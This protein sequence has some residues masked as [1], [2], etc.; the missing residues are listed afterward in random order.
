MTIGH[1]ILGEG[2]EKVIVVHGWT[3]DHTVFA[4]MFPALDLKTYSYAFI[5]YRGYGASREIAGKFTLDEICADAVALADHLGWERFHIVGHSQGGKAVQ[6]IAARNPK[7]VK[8]VIALTA[9]PAS[10]VPL[11]G[12]QR[13]L[14]EGAADE[15]NNRAIIIDVTTGNRLSR[16][17]INAL[18]EKSLDV[19]RRDAFAAYFHAWADGDLSAEVKGCTVPLKA[20]VGEHD[21][22]ITADVMK[23]TVL[24]WFPG[25]ELEVMA[26]AGHYPMQETPIRLATVW[27]EWFARHG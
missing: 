14:F 15:A 19:C 3:S 25:S 7:R 17:W 18:V 27:E 6:L 10:G 2:S 24:Q 9:V 26:N 21:V 22:A 13:A 23:A 1:R 16:T 8:S 4:P 12:Q 20:V 5:D 11:E